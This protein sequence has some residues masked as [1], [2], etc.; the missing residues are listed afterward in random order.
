VSEPNIEPNLLATRTEVRSLLHD[1]VV[2]A[3]EEVMREELTGPVY[4]PAV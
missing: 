4:Q 1:R 3:V 2:M